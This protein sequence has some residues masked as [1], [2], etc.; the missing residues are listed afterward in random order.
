[1]CILALDHLLGRTPGHHLLFAK[2][3]TF[4]GETTG[5][6]AFGISWLLASHVIPVLILPQE[7]HKLG[8]PKRGGADPAGA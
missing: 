8:M 3:L 4:I 2:N 1:M 5:L 7:R 6:L